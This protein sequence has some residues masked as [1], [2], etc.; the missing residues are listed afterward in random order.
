M[1]KEPMTF[2]CP[3][4]GLDFVVNDNEGQ[5]VCPHCGATASKTDAV[6]S[7]PSV[8]SQPAPAPQ[9]AQ[10]TQANKGH[11]RLR[12]IMFTIWLVF[13]IVTIV[14][15]FYLLFIMGGRN[16]L[17]ACIVFLLAGGLPLV[18]GGAYVVFKV[19]PEMDES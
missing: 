11:K 1:S 3:Q 18:G 10:T 14:S 19:I 13:T 9:P 2:T 17:I 8:S 15:C 4:C 12:I 6:A 5:A 16:G 7:K